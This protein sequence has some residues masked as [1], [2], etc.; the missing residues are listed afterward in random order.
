MDMQAFKYAT[1][2]GLDCCD[3]CRYSDGCVRGVRNYRNG[4]I[5]PPCADLDPQRWVDE[6]ALLECVKE[7]EEMET[8][9]P[10]ESEG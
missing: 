1:E 2:N 7:L 6:E 3:F 8:L 5:Y 4:P 10:D 9:E